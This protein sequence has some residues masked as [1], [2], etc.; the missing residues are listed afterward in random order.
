LAQRA[1]ARAGARK[2]ASPESQ[3]RG[4]ERAKQQL[5]AL[6]AE[7]VTEVDPAD[8]VSWLVFKNADALRAQ[9]EALLDPADAA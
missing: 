4:F 1:R 7:L 6:G 3:L 2:R 8:R 5:R 9:L